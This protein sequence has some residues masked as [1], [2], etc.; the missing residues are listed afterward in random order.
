MTYT[1]RYTRRRSWEKLPYGLWREEG[2]TQRTNIVRLIEPCSHRIHNTS[3]YKSTLVPPGDYPKR[4]ETRLGV[5]VKVIG[6]LVGR[7]WSRLETS[8]QERS[9]ILSLGDLILFNPYQHLSLWD[10]FYSL[11]FH[12]NSPINVWLRTPRT[13]EEKTVN[14][15]SYDRSCNCVRRDHLIWNVPFPCFTTRRIQMASFSCP[16]RE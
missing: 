6:S 12:R 13:W 11:H 16:S 15:M 4:I 3:T 9:P 8:K 5:G 7:I 2:S 14:R 1:W 10:D